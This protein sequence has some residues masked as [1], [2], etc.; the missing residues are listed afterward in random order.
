[1]VEKQDNKTTPP[2]SQNRQMPQLPKGVKKFEVRLN[3]DPRKI[4]IWILIGFLV[5]SFIFS[6][7]GPVPQGEKTLSEVLNS[8]KNEEIKKIEVEGDSLYVTYNDGNLYNTRKEP[9]VSF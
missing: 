2:T 8:I 4:L 5:L 9:Q 7:K 6:L 1:M 3:F